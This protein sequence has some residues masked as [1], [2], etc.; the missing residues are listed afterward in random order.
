MNTPPDKPSDRVVLPTIETPTLTK[1]ELA[2]P[3]A[4][5]ALAEDLRSL[6]PAAAVDV[7]RGEPGDL[8]TVLAPPSAAWKAQRLS[9]D[10]A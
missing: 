10:S 6:N 2:D 7:L 3:N 4:I 1:A 5:S 8:R 9:V